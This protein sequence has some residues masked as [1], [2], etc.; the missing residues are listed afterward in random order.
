MKNLLI[1]TILIAG[2]GAC[3]NNSRPDPDPN[4]NDSAAVEQRIVDTTLN[5]P[6]DSL[7]KDTIR[8][9]TTNRPK[10]GVDSIRQKY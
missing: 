10:G 8:I 7:R 9:D 5:R 4:A 3:N 6:Y 1:A 2:L